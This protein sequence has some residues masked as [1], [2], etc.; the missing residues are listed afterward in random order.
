MSVPYDSSNHNTPS[1][2]NVVSP[3]SQSSAPAPYANDPEALVKFVL[4]QPNLAEQVVRQFGNGMFNAGT[5]PGG[6]PQVQYPVL[7]S[8]H[9]PQVPMQVPQQRTASS[10]SFQQTSFQPMYHQPQTQIYHPSQMQFQPSAPQ[11]YFSQYQQQELFQQRTS[12]PSVVHY[13]PNNPNQPTFVQ[14][15]QQFPVFQ[16]NGVDH[17]PQQFLERMNVWNISEGRVNQTATD[18]IPQPVTTNQVEKND[19]CS[20]LA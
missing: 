1:P 10:S 17:I 15:T 3:S 19:S 11:P 9:R 8:L 5:I 20:L 6:S 12:S 7:Q 2:Q 16:T 4:S 18:P 14:Q 13:L